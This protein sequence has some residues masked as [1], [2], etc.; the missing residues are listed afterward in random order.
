MPWFF[1]THYQK[2][3]N[4]IRE[5]T[6]DPQLSVMLGLSCWLSSQTSLGKLF[7]SAQHST[8]NQ[9]TC[10]PTLIRG[11][12][13]SWKQFA[14][15]IERETCLWCGCDVVVSQCKR[16]TLW[17]VINESGRPLHLFI[18]SWNA[19]KQNGSERECSTTF[20]LIVFT[21]CSEKGILKFVLTARNAK[22]RLPTEQNI[23][24]RCPWISVD[25][26]VCVR[27]D[28]KLCTACKMC[29]HHHP[30]EP[31]VKIQVFFQLLLFKHT[32]THTH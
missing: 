20:L 29:V 14:W 23:K 3:W 7:I 11:I 10:L 21:W 13:A 30:C 1:K 12:F 4:E 15:S 25:K 16:P 22:Q 32:Q 2:H 18:T 9:Y 31:V 17:L 27:T 5:K 19:S 24:Y 8:S 26:S 28:A 6:C